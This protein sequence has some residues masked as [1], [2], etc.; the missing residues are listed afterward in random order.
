MKNRKRNLIIILLISLIVVYLVFKDDPV[1]KIKC[2]FSFNIIWL[3]ISFSLMVIYWIFKGIS[4]YYIT[5]KIDKTFT[6]KD[7]IKLM[8]STQLFHAITPFASGGQPWQIYKL[9]KRGVSVGESTNIV[10]EDFITYQIALILLGILAVILNH[11]L[12]IIPSTSHLRYLVLV[13]FGM[14]VL[15]IIFLFIVAFSKKWNKRLIDFGIKVL[16]KFK[17]IKDKEKMLQKSE[18][19]INNFH[20]GA[21]TL[22]S[23]KLNFIRITLLNFTALS[24]QYLVPFTLM[25]GLGIFVNPIYIV[26]CSAYVMLIDSMIPTPGSTGGL[27]YGFMSFF[28]PFASGSKLSVIMIVWRMI[29]YYFGIIMGFIFINISEKEDK[30]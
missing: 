28:K 23:D 29:T 9:K 7:S 17:V 8:I 24:F 27:E 20:G 13:G 1:E 15:V 30:K 19:F 12:N 14:N 25:L 18:E 2:L 22:F 4:F 26:T 11:F 10:I 21:K 3:L 5:R 16:Y 6:I